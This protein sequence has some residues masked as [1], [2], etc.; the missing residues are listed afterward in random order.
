MRTRP[1]EILL[2]VLSGLVSCLA[3]AWGLFAG[4]WGG[5]WA[6]SNIGDHILR[7]LFWLL[8]ATSLVAFGAYFYSRKLGMLW[9]WVIAIGSMMTLFTV[10]FSPNT[11]P[12]K[13]AWG[14]LIQNQVWILLIPA[15]GLYFSAVIHERDKF[16]AVDNRP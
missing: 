1:V 16:T 5:F 11:N 13:I 14:V 12:V 3:T 4:L 10:N 9:S 2:L 15:F 6:G 7:L 8:P